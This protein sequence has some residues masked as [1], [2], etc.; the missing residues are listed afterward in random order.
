LIFQVSPYPFNEDVV[1]EE[2]LAFDAGPYTQTFQDPEALVAREL[3]EL[4]A[5][6]DLWDVERFNY[7]PKAVD[8]EAFLHSV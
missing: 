3:G 6:M 1:Q 5:V 8:I 2:S 7:L 4:V